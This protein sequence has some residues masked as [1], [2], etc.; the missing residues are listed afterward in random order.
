[1]TCML[2]AAPAFGAV[3]AGIGVRSRCAA[4]GRS[5]ARF[6]RVA[7][8][9]DARLTRGVATSRWSV[10][11][12]EADPDEEPMEIAF[13]VEGMMCDGCVETVTAVLTGTGK[14]QDVK[15]DLDAKTVK[16]FVA[17]D[18]MMDGLVM[19]PTLVDALKG[20]GFDAEPDF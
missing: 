16:V 8:G 4:S 2:L 5:S 9:V 10:L 18:S 1:M 14:V 15:V 20:A 19:I 12:A 6:A 3:G 13:K 17:C 7:R 11:S